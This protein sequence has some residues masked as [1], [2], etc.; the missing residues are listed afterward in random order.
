MFWLKVVL[1]SMILVL[2]GCG[3]DS[4]PNNDNS[5]G[6]NGGDDI[7][8]TPPTIPPSS[9]SIRTAD[10]HLTFD[11]NTAIDALN[12]NFST[13]V[14]SI[15][16]RA[17]SVTQ[18]V[19][20]SKDKRCQ[21]Q[22][23]EPSLLQFAISP[24][25]A[26][27]CVY[28]YTVTDG[29][30]SEEGIGSITFSAKLLANEQ[31]PK[32]TKRL[33]AP[34]SLPTI[35]KSTTQGNFLAFS[36]A[37]ELSV[38]LSMMTN[39]LFSEAIT[40]Y[41]TGVPVITE[42]G[43]VT[44]DAI[45]TG[46]SIAY[47][48]ILDDQNTP[49]N[50]DDDVVYNGTLIITVSGATNT[51]PDASDATYSRLLSKGENVEIDISNFEGMS[52]ISDDDLDRIQLVA[53]YTTNGFVS[54]SDPL[55][56]ENTTF[57]Y[58]SNEVGSHSVVYV[59]YDHNNN[60]F[61]SG[62][63]Q[64]STGEGLSGK[65]ELSYLGMLKYF[66]DFNQ[67]GFIG[68]ASITKIVRDDVAPYISSKNLLIKDIKNVGLSNYIIELSNNEIL[69]IGHDFF[70][71]LENV[72]LV[73]Q[74]SSFQ[75]G[76]SQYNESFYVLFND[77]TVKGYDATYLGNKNKPALFFPKLNALNIK[78]AKIIKQVGHLALYVEYQ[79]KNKEVF[80]YNKEE[81][82]KV[83]PLEKDYTYI[84]GQE[85]VYIPFYL[86]DEGR[87]Y[88]PPT[89]PIDS[90]SYK[91]VSEIND[92]VSRNDLG[93]IVLFKRRLEL[94]SFLTD[95][96][97]LLVY[98]QNTKSAEIVEYSGVYR[99]D[100]NV[101]TLAYFKNENLYVKPYE[102]IV[103]NSTTFADLTVSLDG[104]SY[105][106]DVQTV[107]FTTDLLIF[108]K[109]NGDLGVLSANGYDE[110][111]DG[112][113][114]KII[115]DVNYRGDKGEYTSPSN[116]FGKAGS[117]VFFAKRKDGSLA[118]FSPL[119]TYSSEF[120]FQ[121]DE[122]SDFHDFLAEASD[123]LILYGCNVLY[124]K[125]NASTKSISNDPTWILYPEN[126]FD[127]DKVEFDLFDNDDFDSDGLSNKMEDSTCTQDS[128][129]ITP[130]M[131][132]CLNSLFRDSDYDSVEDD[133]ELRYGNFKDKG[134]PLNTDS[135]LYSLSHGDTPIS[136]F[137]DGY[138]DINH[139]FIVDMY[140]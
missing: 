94:F 139:N 73:T 37:D 109:K 125:S 9:K 101:Y 47:F 72:K 75:N 66:K 5:G 24:K 69:L 100:S 17:L 113:Y 7:E 35:S 50:K 65:I 76:T 98:N 67:V 91:L 88:A 38:E 31:S 53:V 133:F 95:K 36:L 56:V 105:F 60:G 103:K 13:F 77:G 23:I 14:S 54:L 84:Y 79:N 80:V 138:R 90:D 48:Y 3:G 61:S 59:V 18:V 10:F 140:D 29:E 11:T 68:D 86:I 70:K 124:V 131:N 40:A 52:L 44:Y 43:E 25:A 92:L 49:N 135:F 58:Q 81:G 2:T 107:T 97:A 71:K 42:T 108:I 87:L 27:L 99:F 6:L 117:N 82:V 4:A 39:P 130:N 128:P 34:T 123:A 12:V 132:H 46:S 21:V 28:R 33:L 83:Y 8:I 137:R 41:G 116:L 55:N 74:D 45:A 129:L 57:N 134:N 89:I 120:D 22:G 26:K 62:E 119:S 93:K 32:N 106:K 127:E 104:H 1:Y 115:P 111:N 96:G 20:L 136:L 85:L 122:T 126:L 15:E 78:E 121:C 112:P 110:Y 63:I 64:I 118:Y 30:T 51:P 16:N 19:P 102:H 114:I